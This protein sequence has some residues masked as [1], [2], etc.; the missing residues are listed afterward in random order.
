MPSS[1]SPQGIYAPLSQTMTDSES[2]EEI[3]N[4]SKH[5][6]HH[7]LNQ[8]FRSANHNNSMNNSTAIGMG[9]MQ[10]DR[11]NN[12]THLNSDSE[13]RHQ[14]EADNVA[15]LGRDPKDEPMSPLRRLAFVMSLVLCGLTVFIILWAAPCGDDNTCPA[16]ADRVKSHNWLNNYTKVELKGVVNVVEG[17]RS[18]ERNLIFM[19]RGDKFFPE[20]EQ[21]NRKRNGI[22]SLIGS[23]GA[24]AWFDEMVNEPVTI[25]CTLLDVDK[26]GK[27]DCL[28]IDEF[29]QL[30]AINPV[31]GQWL[32]RFFDQSAQKVD[33]LNFPVI[34]PDLDGD[35]VFEL[36]FATNKGEVARNY[37]RILSGRT[38]RP[39]GRGYKV[40]DCSYI[41]KF[42]LDNAYTVSFNCVNNDTEVQRFKSLQELYS[43][44]TNRAIGAKLTPASLIS[45]HKLYGQRKETEAQ[46][47]IYSINDKQLIVENRGKCPENC[48]V[49]F[50][51]S[52]E[53]NGVSHIIRNFSGSMMY[54]MVPAQLSFKGPDGSTKFNGFVIKFW[55]WSRNQT[56]FPSG[57]T[58][59]KRDALLF[60][61]NYNIFDHL[62]HKR[63]SY[64]LPTE[65]PRPER[66]AANMTKQR[67]NSNIFLNYKMRMIKETVVLIIFNSADTHIENTSQSNIVQF[68]RSEKNEMSCQPDLNN[69][70]NSLLIADLDQDGSQELVS[71]YSTFVNKNGNKNDWKLVTYVQL[72]RLESELPILYDTVKKN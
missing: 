15:I 64:T 32:W 61:D 19:Y 29:G 65:N 14:T 25:D 9:H 68:C 56:D 5:S 60:D 62:I 41:H 18:W 39:I 57:N 33:V 46:R 71:Y 55:E 6:R 10:Y 38:G 66:S 21:S 23:S 13:E 17:V 43:L 59:S 42:Q 44:T 22:I 67:T 7:Q 40:T 47:N 51:L 1:D 30:G 35:G 24:I 2:E 8:N 28:V 63:R 36:L 72:L 70:E 45:Q 54:G 27:P 34:L 11:S 58:R 3:H 12:M 53:K 20:F 16:P 48:N 4:S 31:S 26:N 37:L 52:E 69:Q 50:I 49:T